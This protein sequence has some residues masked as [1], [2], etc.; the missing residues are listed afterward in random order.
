M[1]MLLRKTGTWPVAPPRFSA[2]QL[3]GKFGAI[4]RSLGSSISPRLE[5]NTRSA[6]SGYTPDCEPQMYPG[7]GQVFFGQFGST[8]YGPLISKPP[9][10][11]TYRGACV[12][13]T[14]PIDGKR[15]ASPSRTARDTISLRMRTS[16]EESEPAGRMSRVYCPRE[17]TESI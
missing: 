9:R 2:P 10:C 11:S 7:A 15:A 1:R 4:L 6:D 12:C 8:W 17:W 16:H 5:R 13:W 14:N 3:P